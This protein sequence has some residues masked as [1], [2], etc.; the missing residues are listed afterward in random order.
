MTKKQQNLINLALCANFAAIS[1]VLGRF[2]S[3]NVQDFSIGLGF[4]PVMLCAMTCGVWWGGVCGALADFLGALLFPFG[5][6]FPGFTA[7]AF[8]M[9]A[10]YGVCG[11][12]EG[13][14][15]RGKRFFALSLGAILLGEALGTLLLNSFWLHFLYGRPYVAQIVLRVPQAAFYFVVKTAAAVLIARFILPITK[16]IFK[17]S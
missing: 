9:G 10:L 14:Y 5:T 11:V 4:L 6:Y 1:V 17:R 15:G 12:A 13:K 3:Y 7:V 8:L 2:F 16:K